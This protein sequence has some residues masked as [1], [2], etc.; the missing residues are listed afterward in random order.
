MSESVSKLSDQEVTERLSQLGGWQ[1]EDGKLT[2]SFKFADF[3][4]AV[5][6][7]NKVARVAEAQ[8]HHPDLQVSWGLVVVSLISHSVGALTDSDFNLASMIDQL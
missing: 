6:F 3:M 2:K 1:V 5:E 4:G 7:V 8:G